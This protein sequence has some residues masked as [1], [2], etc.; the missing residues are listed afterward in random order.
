MKFT[1]LLSLFLSTAYT[2]FSDTDYLSTFGYLDT[3]NSDDS[4]SLVIVTEEAKTQALRQ[5]QKYYGL[6]ETGEVDELTSIA[7]NT[8]RCGVPDKDGPDEEIIGMEKTKEKT[9]KKNRRRKSRRRGKRFI[10]SSTKWT[11]TRLS[12]RFNNYTSDLPESLTRAAFREAFDLWEEASALEF[13]EETRSQV[14]ADIEIAYITG[15]HNDQ[16]VFNNLVLGHAFFPRVGWLHMNDHFMWNH[17]S[18]R[19]MDTMFVAVHELGHIL[20]LRHS[21]VGSIMHASYPGYTSDIKLSQDDID[22]IQDLYGPNPCLPNNPCKNRGVCSKSHVAGQKVTCACTIGWTGRKCQTSIKSSENRKCRTLIV[23]NGKSSPAGRPGP[24]QEVKVYCNSGF[25]LVGA[26][27]FTCSHRGS[28]TPSIANTICRPK[29]LCPALSIANGQVYPRR[30]V[31]A[32]STVSFSCEDEFQ[33]SGSQRVKCRTD[34]TYD[35]EA[36][37]CEKIVKEEKDFCPESFDSLSSRTVKD[38]MLYAFKGSRYWIY[39][40]DNNGNPASHWKHSGSLS[41]GF[42]NI[43]TDLDAV[44]SYS[45]PVSRR[46]YMCF[47]KWPQVY[48]WDIMERDIKQIADFPT[49]FQLPGS[50]QITAA[51]RWDEDTIYF[52]VPAGY[53]IYK[54]KKGEVSPSFLQPMSNMLGMP[55]S[56]TITAASR[57]FNDASFYLFSGNKSFQVRKSD[58]QLMRSSPRKVSDVWS[59]GIDVC[60]TS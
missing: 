30:G 56:A 32:E 18:F 26:G 39:T 43:P 11:D 42:P 47:V 31:E 16:S 27:H 7:M 10:H 15:V 23:R 38:S 19:G 34:G 50:Q 21:K 6:Q 1:L 48:F 33:L 8:P 12:F 22:G 35:R 25:E 4:E 53:Y 24:G 20:G 2:Q 59:Q 45:H 41:D 54:I 55:L 49:T 5:F 44:F 3:G 9:E 57:S 36:P 29:I 51:L 17:K 13:Y 37:T 14:A 52:F 58:K 60:N 46:R 28:Y 40:E